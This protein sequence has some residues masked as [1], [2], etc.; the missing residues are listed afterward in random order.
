MSRQTDMDPGTYVPDIGGLRFWD[1]WKEVV[2]VFVNDTKQKHGGGSETGAGAFFPQY[3]KYPAM[4]A[5]SKTKFLG[6]LLIL[7]RFHKYNPVFTT[8]AGDRTI[9][10]AF[11]FQQTALCVLAAYLFCG[12]G[13]VW[14]DWIDRDIDAKVAR[15]KHRPLA[16]GSVTTTEAMVWMTLQVI[17]SWGVLRVMLDNKDVL[18]HLIPVMV[19]SVLY[20]FGKRY[21][22]RKLMIYPQYILAFTIAWPAIPGRAAICGRHESFTETTRQCLPLCIMVFFWTIYL[23]TAYSYQDVV[24]DRKLKVNSFYNIAGNHIHVLLVLLVSPIIL[25][26]FDP[27]QPASGGTLH[28]SNFILG[29]WTILACAAEVF[30]T[31]A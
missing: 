16:M 17:M 7:S 20:P 19:A 15:T 10:T 23:N 28:K 6:E 1:M 26:Q 31:S 29:V 22:A 24:D 25:A 3:S 9:S 2:F 13:M 30:L 11:V 5:R 8:F 14:N 21:L 4:A 27:K 12:A 18:K